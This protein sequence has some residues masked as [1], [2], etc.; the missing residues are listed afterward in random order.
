ML[1]FRHK[2]QTSKNVVN[3]TFNAAGLSAFNLVERQICHNLTSA[4]LLHDRFGSHLDVND[5]TV[6]AE[7]ER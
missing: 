5:M 3:T 7:L 4:V 6:D 1:S 2:K